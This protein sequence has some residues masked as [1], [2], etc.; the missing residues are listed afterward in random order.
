MVGKRR[1]VVAAD[2]PRKGKLLGATRRRANGVT[3]T[4]LASCDTR[5][6]STAA[7]VARP[8]RESGAL[9]PVVGKDGRARWHAGATATTVSQSVQSA[10]EVSPIRVWSVLTWLPSESM[11]ERPGAEKTM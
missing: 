11:M 10:R 8:A 5:A 9:D 3:A 4:G 6:A 7:S 1:V 2:P